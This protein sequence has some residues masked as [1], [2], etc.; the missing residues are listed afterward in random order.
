MR[1]YWGGEINTKDPLRGGGE[2][3]SFV[4]L[5]QVLMAA[6]G[7]RARSL[8]PLRDDRWEAEEADRAIWVDNYELSASPPFI[9]VFVMKK[10]RVPAFLVIK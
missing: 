9:S 10:L 3:D 5:G 7:R 1:F 4:H 6:I 2:R 8:R